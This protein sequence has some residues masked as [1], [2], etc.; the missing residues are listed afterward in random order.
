MKCASKDCLRFPPQGTGNSHNGDLKLISAPQCTGTHQS[1]LMK[2]TG[3][4]AVTLCL[5]TKAAWVLLF[6][7]VVQERDFFLS[8]SSKT[9]S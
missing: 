8:F 3:W 1:S 4:Q 6:T 7:F 5:V 9:F 2:G